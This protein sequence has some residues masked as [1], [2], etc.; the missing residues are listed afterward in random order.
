M[1][2]NVLVPIA[3]A[4]VGAIAAETIRYGINWRNK[5]NKDIEQWYEETLNSISHG[6]NICKS[7]RKRSNLD[8]G[9][10]SQE[11]KKVAQNLNKKKKINPYSE[12]C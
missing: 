7:E 1:V 3:S 11:S 9:D 12:W 5:K 2:V 6:H 4:V 8:Y 10:I